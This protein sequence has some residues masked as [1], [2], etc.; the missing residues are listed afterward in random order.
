MFCSGVIDTI[1]INMYYIRVA[2]ATL[3]DTEPMVSMAILP[4]RHSIK[5]NSNGW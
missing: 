3:Y 5:E 1:Y 2:L 4:D